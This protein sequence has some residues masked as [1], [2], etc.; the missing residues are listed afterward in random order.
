MQGLPQQPE[1]FGKHRIGHEKHRDNGKLPARQRGSGSH[2]ALEKERAAY[3][4]DEL[5]HAQRDAKKMKEGQ[6]DTEKR[7]LCQRKTV[8]L[9]KPRRALPQ[10]PVENTL[11]V[12]NVEAIVDRDPTRPERT[13]PI[14]PVKRKQQQAEAEPPFPRIPW[15]PHLH[16]HLGARRSATKMSKTPS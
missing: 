2:R 3:E 7:G 9:A 5:T 1:F 13:P 12:A 11:G 6:P 10:V 16:G 4:Q 15:C 8:K 14:E